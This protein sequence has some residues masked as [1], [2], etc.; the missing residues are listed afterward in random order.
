MTAEAGLAA[1]WLAAA[2]SLLGLFLSVLHVRGKLEA[3]QSVR[4][5][6]IVQGLLCLFAFAML[7]FRLA[8]AF[9]M[10]ALA[11]MLL[12]AVSAQALNPRAT[13]AA[14]I[15]P[16]SLYCI[17]EPTSGLLF[18]PKNVR[19]NQNVP[20]REAFEPDERDIGASLGNHWKLRQALGQIDCQ[21]GDFRWSLILW[22]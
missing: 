13:A 21:I 20:P 14:S 12:L 7:L 16:G 4:G 19:T 8:L 22:E 10:L 15:I 18:S 6:A 17:R 3:D 2:L 1:L 11:F 9:A 5:L